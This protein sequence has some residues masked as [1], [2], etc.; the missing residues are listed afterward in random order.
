MLEYFR[1]AKYEVFLPSY[2][3]TF[4]LVFDQAH[5]ISS[6]FNEHSQYDFL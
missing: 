5:V 4:F 6:H 1:E 2:Q 3:I